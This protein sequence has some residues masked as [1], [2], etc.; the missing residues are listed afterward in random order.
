[1]GHRIEPTTQFL[2]SFK[3]TLGNE[4]PESVIHN[5]CD[6]PIRLLWNPGIFQIDHFYKHTKKRVPLLH[7]YKNGFSFR[8]GKGAWDFGEFC[9]WFMRMF[10]P[11]E[12]N[13]ILSVRRW[14]C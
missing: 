10:K 13:D 14:G 11:I 2:P 6:S 9:A 12:R 3:L 8:E 4:F 1:M 5:G 7:V